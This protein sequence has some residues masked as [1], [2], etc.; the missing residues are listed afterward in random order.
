MARLVQRLAWSRVTFMF[1]A[2]F[3]DFDPLAQRPWLMFSFVFL[4]DLGVT[5]LVMA[6]ETIAIAQSIAGLAVFALLGFWTEVSLTDES[7]NAALAFYFLF[8]IVHSALPTCY[9]R[10]R[11]V[12]TQT[13]ANH[14][15]PVL[16]LAL[17]LVPVFT[18]AEVSFIVWPFI[19]LVDLLAI[20]LA[21]WTDMLLPV[22]AVLLF[23]LAATGELIFKI[24]SDLSGLPVS[25]FLLGTFAVFFAAAGIWLVRTFQPDALENRDQIRQ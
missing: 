9:K 24:P 8:A 19:L 21:V 2:W 12:T 7:L 25:F 18:L 20:A 4:V 16:A 22:L 3:L 6:D 13:W 14:I 11:G 10:R 1:T 17:V 5:A 23:T 15:F